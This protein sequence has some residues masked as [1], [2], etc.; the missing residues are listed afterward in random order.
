MLV[1]LL[2]V[3]GAMGLLALFPVLM[4]VSWMA[5]VHGWVGLG[6]MPTSPIVE[7][8]TRSVSALYA[9]FGG[10]LLVT[11]RDVRRNRVTV[12]YLAAMAVV[13]GIAVLGIDLYAGL[14][15]SWILGEGPPTALFGVILLR[16]LRAVPR[17]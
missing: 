9:G 6:E 3:W 8:L 10:L 2:R 12:T 4:P 7:Y 17:S 13:F 14:P 5:A 15:L 11:S 1:I 16:L